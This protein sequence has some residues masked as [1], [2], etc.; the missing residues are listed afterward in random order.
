M[1]KLV[2]TLAVAVALLFGAGTA[3]AGEY[4]G[5]WNTKGELVCTPKGHDSFSGIAIISDS[6]ISG[7]LVG[8]N[9]NYELAIR[10]DKWGRVIGYIESILLG[11]NPILRVQGTFLIDNA[12]INFSAGGASGAPCSGSMFLRRM[13]SETI[14]GTKVLGDDSLEAKLEKLKKLLEKG[15][16]TE[17]E[18]A[19]KRAKFLE[20]L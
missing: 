1:R 5:K 20:D 3:W 16:I 8:I 7:T 17:E 12:N 13:S 6:E 10:I 19:A 11:Y 4:D 18:A 15:L 9:R 2:A 14:T